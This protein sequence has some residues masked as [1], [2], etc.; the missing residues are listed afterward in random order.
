[1]DDLDLHVEGAVL[2]LVAPRSDRPAL[3]WK[4]Q[5]RLPE[6]VDPSRIEARWRRGVLQLN[7]PDAEETGPIRVPVLVEER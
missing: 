1:M 3:T 7:L 2:T 5:V 4:R 6:G